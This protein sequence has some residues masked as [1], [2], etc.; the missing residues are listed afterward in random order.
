MK[1]EKIL[2]LIELKVELIEAEKENEKEIEE[3]DVFLL[4]EGYE[5]KMKRKIEYLKKEIELLK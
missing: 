5:G 1:K 4:N 2:K 3:C